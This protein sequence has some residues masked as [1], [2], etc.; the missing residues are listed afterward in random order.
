MRV[1]RRSGGRITMSVST[2]TASGLVSR[3]AQT[4]SH[5]ASASAWKASA[6]ST[7]AEGPAADSAVRLNPSISI[8]R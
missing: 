8:R 3:A 2:T 5:R 4:S 6:S 7:Y 1:A